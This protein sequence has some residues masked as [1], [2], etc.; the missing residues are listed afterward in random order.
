MSNSESSIARDGTALYPRL[1]FHALVFAR[2]CWRRYVLDC[3]SQAVRARKQM[4]DR[5]AKI[6]N[7]ARW[8]AAEAVVDVVDVAEALLD[9]A[10]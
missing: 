10:N 6:A 7:E 4:I 5:G 1:Y 2:S 9:V 3:G 8:D